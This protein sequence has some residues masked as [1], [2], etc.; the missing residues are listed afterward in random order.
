MQVVDGV[1]VSAV[2]S[3]EGAVYIASCPE[4]GL[5]VRGESV[6]EALTGLKEALERFFGKGNVSVT[7]VNVTPS[8]RHLNWLRHFSSKQQE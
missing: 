4:F 2:V 8:V 5:S 6:D 7:T 3:R 1:E